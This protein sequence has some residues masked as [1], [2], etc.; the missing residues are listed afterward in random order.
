MDVIDTIGQYLTCKS[1]NWEE[2]LKD[3]K[4]YESNCVFTGKELENEPSVRNRRF[5]H[6]RG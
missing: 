6:T 2:F 5:V 3:S 1:Q 4:V